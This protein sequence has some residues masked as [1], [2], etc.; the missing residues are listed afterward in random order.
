M[1]KHSLAILMAMG[2]PKSGSAQD[3]GAPS[4]S[5]SSPDQGGD[6]MAPGGGMDEDEGGQDP[7][8][9][10]DKYM[11]PL[12]DGFKAPGGDGDGS[13]FTTTIQCSI[14]DGPNG[15]MLDISKI[16]DMPVDGSSESSG[17]D[18]EDMGE[19]QEDQ[20]ET[21]GQGSQGEDQPSPVLQKESAKY[22]KKRKDEKSAKMAFQGG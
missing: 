1:K 20:T 16:G 13:V 17:S 9:S 6:A 12:P 2:G 14:V 3:S 10:Q 15:K 18:S 7:D 21:S 5:I 11:L 22:S 8:Q 19:Q 4:E